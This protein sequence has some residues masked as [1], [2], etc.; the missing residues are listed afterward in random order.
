MGFVSVDLGPSKACVH[1]VFFARRGQDIQVNSK[2]EVSAMPDGKKKWYEGTVEKV[3]YEDGKRLLEVKKVSW[4]VFFCSI[5]C[6]RKHF[7]R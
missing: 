5:F 2:L 7:L 6:R 1:V 3:K 4:G